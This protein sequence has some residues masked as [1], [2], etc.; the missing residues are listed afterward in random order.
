MNTNHRPP[1][2]M[3]KQRKQD[4]RRILIMVLCTLVIVG[5][6]LIGLWIGPIEMLTAF[7]CLLAGGGAI[8]GLWLF[9]GWIERWLEQR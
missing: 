4:E 2:D 8:L 3:R 9:L 5:G 1:T 6:V 7:P